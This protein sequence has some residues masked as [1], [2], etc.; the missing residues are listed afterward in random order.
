MELTREVV[1]RSLELRDNSQIPV[2][3]VLNK[4]KLNGVNLDNEYLE[5][6]A[7]AINVRKVI[8]DKRDFSEILIELDT[9]ITPTLRL[10]GI[11]RNLIR[12][13][14]NYRK[15]LNL[16]TKNR[17][18]LYIKIVDKEI[19]EAFEKHEE[20]IKKMIQADIIIQNLEGKQDIKKFKI[21][22]KVVEACIEVSN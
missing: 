19:S 14:N 15:K 10:E 9:E 21:E 6:I 22:N 4:V 7:E 17:I 3:Q 12:H 1:K 2:R 18:N 20:R 11:A 13:L 8:I 16:S 5:I